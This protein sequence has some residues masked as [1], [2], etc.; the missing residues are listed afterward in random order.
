MSCLLVQE[1]SDSEAEEE[2][3]KLTKKQSGH[4]DKVERLL[5]KGVVNLDVISSWHEKLK[6]TR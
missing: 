2:R 4:V 1:A 5:A 3:V 6:T